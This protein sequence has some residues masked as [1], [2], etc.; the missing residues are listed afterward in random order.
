M[1]PKLPP[2]LRLAQPQPAQ[3]RQRAAFFGIELLVVHCQ[4]AQAAFLGLE[5][6]A[7]LFLVGALLVEAAFADEWRSS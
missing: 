3:A 6:I 1:S 4:R 2:N 7:L 5:F